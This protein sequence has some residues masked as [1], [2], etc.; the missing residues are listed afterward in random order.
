[1]VMVS[2]SSYR[3][4]P[5]M[6]VRGNSPAVNDGPRRR[7]Q[8]AFSVDGVVDGSEEYNHQA[9]GLTRQEGGYF[10]ENEGDDYN[11]FEY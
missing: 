9:E 5:L 1:M 10:A 3:E 4:S 2:A 7:F 6:E 8:V 11:W